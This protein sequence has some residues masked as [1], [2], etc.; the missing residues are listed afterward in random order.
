MSR[1]TP[2]DRHHIF[3]DI[4]R[5]DPLTSFTRRYADTGYPEEPIDVLDTLSSFKMESLFDY[6]LL[7]NGYNRKK[8]IQFDG[9]A[10]IIEGL[11]FF[12]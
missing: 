6:S 4:N 5:W 3:Q 7:Q 8:I 2:S 9:I 1:F 12:H 11:L 10:P